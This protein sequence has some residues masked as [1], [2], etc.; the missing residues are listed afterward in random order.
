MDKCLAALLLGLMPVFEPRYA[1]PMLYHCYG[2]PGALAAL[3]EAVLLA[4][5]L[6]LL[7]E[8]LWELLLAAHSRLPVLG[9]LVER[10]ERAR[11]KAGSMLERYGTLG[12][13][14][15]VAVPL[16]VTGIYTGAAVALLLG[17]RP[18]HMFAALAAGGTASVAITLTPIVLVH[19]VA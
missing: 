15:F 13:A 8:K 17:L 3:G 16:P 11:E 9:R 19:H 14:L 5:L 10:V 2:V 12:L 4:A 6:T 7:V 1:A 18:R